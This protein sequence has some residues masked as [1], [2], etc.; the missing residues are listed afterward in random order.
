MEPA[1]SKRTGSV[2][3]VAPPRYAETP[4]FSTTRA[5]AAM[6]A[7]SVRALEK[8]NLQLVMGVSPN[9]FKAAYTLFQYMHI[10]LIKM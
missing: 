2:M 4:T 6:V 3:R 10:R 7:T 1:A 8:L 9:D 5:V